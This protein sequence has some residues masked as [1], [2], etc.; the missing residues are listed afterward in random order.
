MM[1]CPHCGL[2]HQI[3]PAERRARFVSFVLGIVAIAVVAYLALRFRSP[4]R[5]GE[6][7]ST[8]PKGAATPRIKKKPVPPKEPPPRE[9]R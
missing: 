2:D 4:E 8:A 1:V 9:P 6:T 3:G 7:E 5:A